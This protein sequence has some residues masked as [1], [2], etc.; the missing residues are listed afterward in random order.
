MSQIYLSESIIEFDK[1]CRGCLGK[2]GDMRPLFGSCLD[3]MLR[4]VC[5]VLISPGDGLP[6]LM[7]VQC[8]LSV[9]RAFTFKQQCEKNDK[10]MRQYIEKQLENS[11]AIQISPEEVIISDVVETQKEEILDEIE[12]KMENHN[13]EQNVVIVHQSFEGEEIIAIEDDDHVDNSSYD[14]EQSI[15]NTEHVML[16]FDDLNS[17]TTIDV[18]TGKIIEN[19]GKFYLNF[20]FGFLCYDYLFELCVLYTHIPICKD[21]LRSTIE[22]SKNYYA[23]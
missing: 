1:I 15:E 13:L 11:A 19:Y 2:K 10:C 21:S 16:E 14:E 20:F 8:V 9:S 18:Q 3:S 6:D 4:S 12:Y 23:L 17:I 22:G 7:C 5:S